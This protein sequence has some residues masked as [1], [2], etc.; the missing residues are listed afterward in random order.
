[1]PRERVLPEAVA[2]E[3]T[4]I[5]EMNIQAGTGTGANPGYVAGGKTGTT[6]D[7]GDAWFAGPIGSAGETGEVAM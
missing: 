4:R 2:F 6:D 7:F 3:V 1:M 5:L